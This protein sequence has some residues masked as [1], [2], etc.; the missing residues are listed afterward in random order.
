[1]RKKPGNPIK[2][3]DEAGV[4]LAELAAIQRDVAAVE[5]EMNEAIDKAKA[6]AQAKCA[7]RLARI[8]E[9][10]ARLSAF[11]HYN[12]AELFS[13]S[14]SREMVHGVIGFRQATSIQA[15]KGLRLADVLD[16]VE[17]LG[18]AEAVRVKKTLDREAMR[19][20]P[21]SMLAA[22]GARRVV[23]D[24]FFYETKQETLENAA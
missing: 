12:K 24:K 17:E 22:V 20:W 9:R 21:D 10:E 4:V 13:K 11:A 3:L 1:M 5:A 23:E 2:T 6:E 14:K 16:K 8:A 7:P 18:M 19:E 15:E